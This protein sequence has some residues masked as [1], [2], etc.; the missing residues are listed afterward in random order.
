VAASSNRPRIS[1]HSTMTAMI[2]LI[3][4][5]VAMALTA[6]RPDARSQA[7]VQ[8]LP[9]TGWHRS[10]PL[11]FHIAPENTTDTTGT[12]TDAT[13]DIVLTIRHTNN[14]PYRNLALVID[15]IADDH[16]YTRLP[17]NISLADDYGNWTSGGFGPYYQTSR[18]I[19]Q[20]IPQTQARTITIWQAMTHCDTLPGLTD[21]GITIT[22]HQ[23]K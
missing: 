15:L 12:A 4:A 7:Q 22:P 20:G 2:T 9:D 10:L 5:V 17:V 16:T 19:A 3:I 21:L 11:T 23:K 6:C 1:G 8:H 13:I 14:Y 18:L